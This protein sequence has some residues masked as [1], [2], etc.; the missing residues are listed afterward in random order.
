MCRRRA[1]RSAGR[2]AVEGEAKE[3]QTVSRAASSD[4]PPPP[5]VAAPANPGVR[6]VQV[7]VGGPSAE[8]LQDESPGR[9]QLQRGEARPAPLCA[10]SPHQNM[11]VRAQILTRCRDQSWLVA[12]VTVAVLRAVPRALAQEPVQT[13][14]QLQE[15]DRLGPVLRR[16]V[17]QR[18]AVSLGHGQ[19]LLGG[20]VSEAVG[21]IL[22][23]YRRQQ[24]AQAE[25]GARQRDCVCAKGHHGGK[26][27]GAAA[28]PASASQA[29]PVPSPTQ[30]AVVC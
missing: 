24:D 9:R 14:T 3:T 25:E 7:S 16:V 10:R 1:R 19:E 22:R 4:D 30:P 18:Q 15:T 23:C 20:E 6:K 12:R 26:D 2:P 11:P 13:Q 27:I 28:A 17:V 8:L 5:P 21:L 29:S